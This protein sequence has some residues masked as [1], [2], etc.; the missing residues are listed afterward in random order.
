MRSGRISSKPKDLTYHEAVD[1]PDTRA[2]FIRRKS[3]NVGFGVTGCSCAIFASVDLQLLQAFT[4]G[5]VNAIVT[6]TKKMPYGMQCI[7]REMLLELRVCIR[8]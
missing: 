8:Y 2:E 4:K 6:S 3:W 1:D 7:A 5:F